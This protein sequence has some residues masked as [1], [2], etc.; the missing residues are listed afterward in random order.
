MSS[1]ALE[2]RK[3]L[4]D[5]TAEIL[6]SGTQMDIRNWVHSLYPAETAHIL[7]SLEAE[8]RAKIW[9]VIPP[10][11]MGEI[12]VEV[13]VEVGAGLLKITDRKDLIAACENMGSDSMVDLLHVLPEPLLSQVIE[14]IGAR[15]RSRFESALGYGEHTAGGLMS[16]EVL[17]VRAD[18]TLDVVARYLRKR[19]KIPPGTESLIVVDRTEQFRGILPLSQFL[20]SDPHSK[21]AD[22]MDSRGVAVLHSTPSR[23]VVRLFEQRK[24]LSLPVVADDGKVMGRIAI[25]DIVGVIREE[26]DHSLM[27]MAGLTEGHDMFAPV[28]T[29]AKRRAVWL[30]IN[31]LTA[32]LAAWVIDLFEDTIQQIVALA[33]LMPIVASMGGIAGSQTLTLV[34]RGLALQQVSAGN[35][36]SLLFKEVSV[37]LVNG[38]VWSAVVAGV[39]GFWFHDPHLGLLLGAAMMINL[40]C[41]ALSGVA[42]PVVLD[43]LGVDPALAGGVLLTTVTDVV[44]FMAFLGLATLFLL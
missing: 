6:R 9:A 43:R 34:I 40:V 21:V 26:A 1:L 3:Q 28:V 14:T 19:G 2:N 15:N 25:D 7:E 24:L 37:G 12:L 18:V 20:A 39:A 5:R 36:I 11:V 33:V 16:R 8:H 30:G 32:F 29:S 27:G 17:T 10:S 13:N 38:L 35:A 31:L 23:D 22:V 4:L 42:I 41:A 44:G